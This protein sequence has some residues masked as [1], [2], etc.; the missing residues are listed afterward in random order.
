MCYVFKERLKALDYYEKKIY[1]V[2]HLLQ[3]TE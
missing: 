1:T 2:V 3:E